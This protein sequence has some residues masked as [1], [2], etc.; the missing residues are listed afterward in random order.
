VKYQFPGR[1]AE[2]GL[3]S[4]R[5]RAPVLDA[6]ITE[7]QYTVLQMDAV[8]DGWV[9][10][11]VIE[12]TQNAIVIGP[13]AKRVTLE[14][15]SISHAAAHTGSAAPADFSISGT[16]ILV[17]RCTV[18]GEGTWP[19]VTQATVTGPI[20]VLNMT[21]DER[22]VSPHQRWATGLLVDHSHFA[23]TAAKTPGIAFSNRN[24]M[25]SGHG[26]DVGWAVGWNVISPFLLVEQ[27]PGAMNWCVGCIGEKVA[28]AGEAAGEFDSPGKPVTPPSL[29]LE[30]LRERLGDAALANIG[31]AKPL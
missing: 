29:Y 18:T 27:P 30:Q 22:G 23:N 15:V 19:L 5:V 16:Q 25:G 13:A 10:D 31:Y 11:V 24:T 2:S 14:N 20:V 26:W 1:I 4:L 9:K 28:V 7:G 8:L 17:S 21:T 3:E 12:E 6:P